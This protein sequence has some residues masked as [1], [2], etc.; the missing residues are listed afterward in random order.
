MG[1][2]IKAGILTVILFG[3]GAYV[4]VS[5]FAPGDTPEEQ[6]DATLKEMNRA[7]RMARHMAPQS[8]PDANGTGLK[9]LLGGSEANPSPEEAAPA[10][11]VDVTVETNPADAN[12]PAGT[13]AADAAPPSEG[14]AVSRAPD[15]APDGAEATGEKAPAR[16]ARVTHVV[17]PGE[18]LC[19]IARDYFGS[20]RHWK[21]IADANPGVDPDRLTI[22]AK[23]VI[24]EPSAVPETDEEDPGETA[25][26][27]TILYKVESGDTLY[28]IARKV[29]GDEK[30]YKEILEANPDLDPDRLSIGETLRI[31]K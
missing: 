21:R 22:G 17:Q 15:G 27:E 7:W 14:D 6:A 3:V 2:L 25:A 5:T 18:T 24:P 8:A 26:S 19:N 10:R 23:L 4:L 29:L 11:E 16:P 9:T 20:S 13:D 12:E 31:R 30:R 1:K 28:A